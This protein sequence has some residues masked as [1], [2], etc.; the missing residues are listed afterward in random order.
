[1]SHIP[2]GWTQIT[3][4]NTTN[5]RTLGEPLGHLMGWGFFEDPV[6]GDEA[7]LLAL[8]LDFIGDDGPLIFQTTEY[9]IPDFL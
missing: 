5:W 8:S 1:M 3:P 9:E 4:T 6:H 2:Q 7:P